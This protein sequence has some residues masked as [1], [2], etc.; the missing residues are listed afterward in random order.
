MIQM[1]GSR[2]MSILRTNAFSSATLAA[3]VGNVSSDS[4]IYLISSMLLLSFSKSIVSVDRDDDASDE[5]R[6]ESPSSGRATS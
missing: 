6:A 5:V 4:S 2:Q 3:S 1:H